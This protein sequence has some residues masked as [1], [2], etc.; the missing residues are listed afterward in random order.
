M[1]MK[2]HF[3]LITDKHTLQLKIM[4]PAIA[5]KHQSDH[6]ND[7]FICSYTMQTA[8]ELY[9]WHL[10]GIKPIDMD[11]DKALKYPPKFDLC[12]LRRCYRGN[13]DTCLGIRD[14]QILCINNLYKRTFGIKSPKKK[15]ISILQAIN[16]R[17]LERSRRYKELRYQEQLKRER[18]LVERKDL[19]LE[20]DRLCPNAKGMY[21]PPN[22]HGIVRNKNISKTL[23][24]H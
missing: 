22:K 10:T 13:K 5:M 15:D 20:I 16:K 2:K 24:N 23:A 9:Y 12:L 8:R 21:V 6:P 1:G 7:L 19:L 17:Q 11:Y 18:L 14:E 3:Y 4:S